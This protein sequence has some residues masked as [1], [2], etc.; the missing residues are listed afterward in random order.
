MFNKLFK[1]SYY[2]SNA[3]VCQEKGDEEHMPINQILH[4]SEIEDKNENR[5]IET[6]IDSANN[7]NAVS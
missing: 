7:G 2:R 5:N 4:T 6:I 1:V 3:S